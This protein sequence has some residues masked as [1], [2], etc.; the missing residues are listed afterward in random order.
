MMKINIENNSHQL[1]ICRKTVWDVN[2]K[3]NTRSQ[4]GRWTSFFIEKRHYMRND[5]NEICRDSILHYLYYVDFNF[6]IILNILSWMDHHHLTSKLESGKR[7][8]TAVISY[9]SQADIYTGFPTREIQG[10]YFH[11]EYSKSRL[12]ES[13]WSKENLFY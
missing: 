2:Q 10:R 12:R 3:W 1:K 5:K 4:M 13:S 9:F 6:C 11:V 8:Q 7:L